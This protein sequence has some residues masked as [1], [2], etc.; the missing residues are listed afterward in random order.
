MLIPFSN[1]VNT[2]KSK[3]SMKLK[4]LAEIEN[5]EMNVEDF[6]IDTRKS[7]LYDHSYSPKPT[8]NEIKISREYLKKMCAEGWPDISRDW[9][10]IFVKFLMASKQLTV[11]GLQQLLARSKSICA[12]GRKH[13]LQSLPF[14]GSFSSVEIMKD[15]IIAESS[16][17]TQEVKEKWMNSIFYLSHPEEATLSTMNSLINF[18]TTDSN[19]MFVLV[20]TAVVSTCKCC[21]IIFGFLSN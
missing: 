6:S 3:T 9:P 11:K 14:I 18:Y 15:L 2:A 5:K 10:E 7:L 1:G 16:E 8:H 21:E 17:I 19:P 12:N 4:L 20:P 13:V